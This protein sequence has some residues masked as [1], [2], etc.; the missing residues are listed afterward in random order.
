MLSAISCSSLRL[1]D[2]I[3]QTLRRRDSAQVR[4]MTR[5]SASR[6]PKCCPRNEP[7]RAAQAR[8]VIEILEAW[9]HRR[10]GR[11]PTCR[12]KHALSRALARGRKVGEVLERSAQRQGNGAEVR[13]RSDLSLGSTPVELER[14]LSI[15]L[16]RW[17]ASRGAHFFHQRPNLLPNTHRPHALPRINH[18]WWGFDTNDTLA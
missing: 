10:G 12:K 9:A 6:C 2:A 7:W 4:M 5:H 16:K 11:G 3:D 8:K 13:R 17:G 1:F 14:D 18:P 15:P